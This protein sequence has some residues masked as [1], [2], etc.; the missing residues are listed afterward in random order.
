MGFNQAI[1]VDLDDH[2]KKGYR[3]VMQNYR[4]G[5]KICLF[6]FSRGSCIARMLAGMIHMIGI[7]PVHNEQLVDFAYENFHTKGRKGNHVCREF[8]KACATS[9][10]VDFVGVWDTV[11]TVG[12][13][14]RQVTFSTTTS[15]GIRVFRHALALDEKRTNFHANTWAEPAFNEDKYI[16][17]G[18]PQ[19][20]AEELAKYGLTQ[21]SKSWNPSNEILPMS[22]KFGLLVSGFS[23]ISS[24]LSAPTK[25]SGSH[26]D[27]GGGSAVAMGDP[28]KIDVSPIPLQWMI[29]ECIANKTG[30]LF[31]HDTLTTIG[32]SW[33]GIEKVLQEDYKLDLK[34]IEPRLVEHM[35]SLPDETTTSSLESRVLNPKVGDS[36]PEP[37]ISDQLKTRSKL[38]YW[39][40]PWWVFE[41]LPSWDAYQLPCGCKEQWRKDLRPNFGWGRYM[42][43]TEGVVRVHSSVKRFIEI[44]GEKYRPLAYNWKSADESGLIEWEN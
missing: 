5:D 4:K 30:I 25:L 18:L 29:K 11:S 38:F 39:A 34:T 8:K 44:P 32:I 10:I 7:L 22:E 27:V 36:I 14:P 31:K 33:H 6:R 43:L 21:S 35:K 12:I 37:R 23:S 17:F 13:V 9:V 42:P 40:S 2:M 41:I 24:Q 28:E 19:S 26:C 15:H 1:A 20:L 3:F 16:V